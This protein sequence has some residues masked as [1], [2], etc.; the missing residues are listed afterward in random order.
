MCDV[1]VCSGIDGFVNSQTQ[2]KVRFL[3][4]LTLSLD[5]TVS[6]SWKTTKIGD[7]QST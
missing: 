2:N 6:A 4:Q 5:V 1:A 3:L 7:Q